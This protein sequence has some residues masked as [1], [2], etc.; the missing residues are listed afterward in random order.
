MAIESRHSA[1]DGNKYSGLRE[2][3]WRHYAIQRCLRHR[4]EYLRYLGGCD[5][6][7]RILNYLAR[8]ALNCDRLDVQ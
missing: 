1:V 6:G 4:V 5:R 8:H 7:V 3:H 2:R